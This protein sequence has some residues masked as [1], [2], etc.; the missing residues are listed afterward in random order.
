M[1]W[2][3]CGLPDVSFKYILHHLGAHT[4]LLVKPLVVAKRG[5]V[6]GKVKHD[7]ALGPVGAVVRAVGDLAEE[8][9]VG[10]ANCI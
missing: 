7:G 6:R 9:K 1:C 5:S 3:L 8:V 2:P 4:K 10:F